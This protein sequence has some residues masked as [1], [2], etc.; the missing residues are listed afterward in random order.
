LS[1][2]R[3]LYAIVDPATT[4][5]PI[6]LAERVLAGG[7]TLLQLRDKSGA[8]GETLLLAKA[9]QDRC[10]ARG[11]VFIVNDRLDVAMAAGA[12][13]V[14]LGQH[15]IPVAAARQIAGELLVIGCSTNTVEEARAAIDAGA[16]YI[17][18]GAMFE[19]SSKRDTRPAGL[20][21]L[22]EIRAAVSAP[23]VAIGGITMD[24]A[25]AVVAAGADMIAVIGALANA[26]DPTSVAS[27]LA[28]LATSRS[29]P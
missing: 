17:G 16:D 3:G 18:V 7:A 23:I 4:A 25:A 6:D 14:H 13:G 10:R 27:R 1:R 22:R 8:A 28:N 19:T 26:G 11:A 29:A 21:R 9:L 5:D 20:E 2:L 12:D 15:D 24:N